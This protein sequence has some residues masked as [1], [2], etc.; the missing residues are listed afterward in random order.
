MRIAALI[1]G[2]LFVFPRVGWADSSEQ[3]VSEQ[4]KKKAIELYRAGVVHYQ[5]G[6]LDKAAVEFKESF[7]T[8][9][10]PETLFNFAQTMRLLKNYE[11]AVYLYRQYLLTTTRISE[12]DRRT[13]QKR[14]E[15]LEQLQKE[16]QKVQTAPP[17]GALPSTTHAPSLPPTDTKP[18][19]SAPPGESKS[20]VHSA[21]GSSTGTGGASVR[22][23]RSEKRRPWYTSKV[24]WGLASIGIVGGAV[25]A[26]LLGSAVSEHN[27][28]IAANT[29]TLFD[30]HHSNVL[31]FQEAGWPLLGVGAAVVVAGIAVFALHAKGRQ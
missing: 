8:Y 23:A 22:S 3:Q 31:H 1:V 21:A 10:T 29:Q 26:G 16:Q 6:D 25:G 28:A 17:Q 14:I 9:P 13:I 12:Q 18:P 30:Q 2:L 7:Q 11:K 19:A 5:T 4:Q 15:D 20:N 27:K 24:G